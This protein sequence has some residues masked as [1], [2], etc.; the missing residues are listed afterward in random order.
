M[1]NFCVSYET[2]A[3]APLL[4]APSLSISAGNLA[5]DPP[6]ICNVYASATYNFVAPSGLTT[7]PL[8]RQ[9]GTVADQAIDSGHG[10]SFN[11]K[12][13]LTAPF[14]VVGFAA[15]AKAEQPFGDQ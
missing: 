1:R 15:A 11:I 3:L 10:G 7:I 2:D 9:W 6:S 13:L 5:V 4:R 8:G 12:Q 14:V